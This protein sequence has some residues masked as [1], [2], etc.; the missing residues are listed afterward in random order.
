M[1]IIYEDD[2]IIV[3]DKPAGLAT[4]SAKVSENDLETELKKYRKKKGEAPEIYMVHRL[5]Q[6][7]SGLLLAAKIKEAAAV[8]SE[9]LKHDEFTKEYVADIYKEAD[10]VKEATLIDYLLKDSRTNSSKVVKKETTGAKRAELSYV[11]IEETENTARL[12]ILLKTGR[13]HQ[14]RVQLAHDNMPLLG[15][16]KYGSEKSKEYSSEHNVRFV[17]L[18]AAKIGFVHPITKKLMTFEDKG[19]TNS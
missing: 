8:L 13:H 14:I 10:F 16:V 17:A 18:R 4:Q 15:D 7:V 3:V 12:K 9:D 11:T 1:K 19:E 5:D 2:A 6:P